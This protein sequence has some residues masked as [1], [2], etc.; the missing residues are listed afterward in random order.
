MDS[1]GYIEVRRPATSMCKGKLVRPFSI[2]E[3]DFLAARYQVGVRI[4]ELTSALNKHFRRARSLAVVHA[5]LVKL[6]LHTP[7]KMSRMTEAEKARID[8][9]RAIGCRV[10]KIALMVGRTHTTISTYLKGR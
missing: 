3:D 10:T 5:R 8:E 7:A 2:P 6:G 9:L 4:S 1:T